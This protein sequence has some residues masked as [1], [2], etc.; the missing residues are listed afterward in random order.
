MKRWIAGF[1]IVTLA[2]IGGAVGISTSV[3]ATHVD[4]TENPD[5]PHCPDT[6]C[7]GPSAIH[8]P[9]CAPFLGDDDD[10]DTAGDDDD[11]TGDDDDVTTGD[12]DDTNGDDDGSTVSGDDDGSS[13]P[14]TPTTLSAADDDD[15]VEVAGVQEEREVVEPAGEESE[16][17]EESGPAEP[18]EAQPSF[19]G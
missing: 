3:S 1:F 15:D 5:H 4:C 8:N 12:D 19:T 17:A 6:V 2:A 13:T 10:D 14:T 18:V 16:P 11:T 9:H 7:T